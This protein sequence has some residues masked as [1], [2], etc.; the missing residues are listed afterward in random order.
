MVACSTR[1]AVTCAESGR[2]IDALIDAREMGWQVS[3]PLAASIIE[4]E[5]M[6][7]RR[8]YANRPNAR[9]DVPMVPFGFANDRWVEF[10]AKISNGDELRRITAP[11]I[12]WEQLR[13]WDGFVL[14][15]DGQVVSAF[16]TLVN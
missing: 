7:E 12:C 14:L 5:A 3:E 9:K 8:E 11:D 1:P 16:M 4:A 6:V 15:R 10:K 13:G 2:A